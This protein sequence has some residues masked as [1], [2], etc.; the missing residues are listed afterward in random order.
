MLIETWE[1]FDID[2]LRTVPS[3]RENPDN[4]L[5]TALTQRQCAKIGGGGWFLKHSVLTIATIKTTRHK[6]KKEHMIYLKTQNKIAAT[7]PE[8]TEIRS[9]RQRL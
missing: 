1:D 7:I 8:E 4:W 5:W 2:R 9:T 6:N 3:L